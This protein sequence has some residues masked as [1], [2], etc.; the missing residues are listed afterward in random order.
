MRN[1]VPAGVHG[2]GE[3]PGHHLGPHSRRGLKEPVVVGVEG[4]RVDVEDVDQSVLVMD[5]LERGLGVNVADE[6]RADHGVSTLEFAA[7]DADYGRAFGGAAIGDGG[8]DRPTDAG[9][10]T[11]AVSYTHL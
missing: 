11:H 10:D 8:T 9:H 4:A 1:P 6:V 7:L 5:A 3:H 2:R